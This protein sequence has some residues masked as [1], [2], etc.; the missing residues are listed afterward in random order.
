M[1]INPSRSLCG[2]TNYQTNHLF[3]QLV[4]SKVLNHSKCKQTMMHSIYIPHC[5]KF[6]H[7]SHSSLW[8]H[9]AIFLCTLQ[10]HPYLRFFLSRT[11]SPWINSHA[12]KR[13]CRSVSNRTTFTA[14][15]SCHNLPRADGLIHSFMGIIWAAG[16]ESR[17]MC[18]RL[19]SCH[20]V[21]KGKL[22]TNISYIWYLL[23]GEL[24]F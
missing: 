24:R 1:S 23:Y 5:V 7:L 6:R 22:S 17:G 14:E 8:L 13:C 4:E 21:R 9:Q 3:Q 11:G 15:S 19:S 18:N 10:T 20:I 16:P 2:V 12:G